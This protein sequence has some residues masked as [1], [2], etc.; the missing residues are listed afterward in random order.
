M[1][2]NL[3]EALLNRSTA[4]YEE[5]LVYHSLELRNDADVDAIRKGADLCGAGAAQGVVEAVEVILV[6]DIAVFTVNL[7]LRDEEIFICHIE[8]A[9]L[10]DHP[11]QLQL[12]INRFR[13]VPGLV[14]VG[15]IRQINLRLERYLS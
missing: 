13:S 7:A 10:H 12:R 9:L 2:Y 4:R 15:I 14:T 5:A 6:R 3:S 8:C 1:Q 11:R